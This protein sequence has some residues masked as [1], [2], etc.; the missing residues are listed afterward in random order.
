[1]AS[2]LKVDELAGNSNTEIIVPQNVRLVAKDQIVR[3]YHKES[4]NAFTYAAGNV[5]GSL[6]FVDTDL[7]LTVKQT[8]PGTKFLVHYRAS[9][10]ISVDGLTNYNSHVIQTRIVRLAKNNI[11]TGGADPDRVTNDS[12]NAD[13]FTQFIPGFVI[14]KGVTSSAEGVNTLRYENWTTITNLGATLIWHEPHLF[15]GMDD[16]DLDF[17]TKYTYRI[18]INGNNAG[19]AGAPISMN[20]LQTDNWNRSSH[21]IIHEIGT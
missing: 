12:S 5:S 1:M 18:Q 14:D 11:G 6:G 7:E 15:T 4:Q 13:Q 2:I 8:L 3:T 19:T 21:I 16:T 9:V 10:D 17:N 20:F